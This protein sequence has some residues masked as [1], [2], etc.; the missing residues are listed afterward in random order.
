MNT[1]NPKRMPI[2][3]KQ[4]EILF[5]SLETVTKDGFDLIEKRLCQK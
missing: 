5:D 3:I 2:I 4:L 1:R